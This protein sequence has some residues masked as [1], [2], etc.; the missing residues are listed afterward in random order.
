M[1]SQIA[2]KEITLYKKQPHRNTSSSEIDTP[3]LSQPAGQSK[4]T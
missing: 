4:K 3:A 1:N 2:K